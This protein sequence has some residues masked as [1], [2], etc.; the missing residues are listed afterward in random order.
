MYDII[1]Y[2]ER[3]SSVIH[4]K[5]YP[6]SVIVIRAFWLSGTERLLNYSAFQSYEFKGTR[7]RLLKNNDE[8]TKIDIYAVYFFIIPQG[9]LFLSVNG[10]CLAQE[11]KYSLSRT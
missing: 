9:L 4:K 10:L 11:L 3:L 6:I 7:R 2:T 1:P 5:P 8:R